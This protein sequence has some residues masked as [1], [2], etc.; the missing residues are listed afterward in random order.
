MHTLSAKE[1]QMAY[2]TYAPALSG[3]LFNFITPFKILVDLQE[4]QHTR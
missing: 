1:N 2:S 3:E 4:D